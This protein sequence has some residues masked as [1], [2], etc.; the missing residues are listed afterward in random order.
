M[1][2]QFDEYQE[3][4]LQAQFEITEEV[5]PFLERGEIREGFLKDMLSIRFN[6]LSFRK[7]IIGSSKNK[8]GQC[9]VIVCLKSAERR[10]LSDHDLVNI[11]DCKIVVEIKSNATGN[12]FKEFNK[13]SKKIKAMGKNKPLCGIFC[14]RIDILKTTLLKR[15]GYK[16]QIDIDGYEW[17]ILN[18]SSLIKYPNMDFVVS[19]HKTKIEDDGGEEDKQLF[20]QLD[21]LKLKPETPSYVYSNNRPIL[22]NFFNLLKSLK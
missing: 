3:K 5:Y 14:Y 15:F 8:S 10:P 13:K 20:L 7:G 12:D 6:H 16:Y 21:P 19:I 11:E 9:D 1:L 18:G 2:D 22:G 4:L 17:D